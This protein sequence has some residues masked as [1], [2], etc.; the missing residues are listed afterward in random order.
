M[1]TFTPVSL[2]EAG[3]AFVA[4]KLNKDEDPEEYVEAKKLLVLWRAAD[5]ATVKVADFGGVIA[6]PETLTANGK[7]NPVGGN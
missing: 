6:A 5:R 2:D 1:S 3:R 4:A 7:I